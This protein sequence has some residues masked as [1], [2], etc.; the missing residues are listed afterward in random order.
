M[1]LDAG[2][3]R[4]GAGWGPVVLTVQKKRR[5]T[6][7]STKRANTSERLVRENW[8]DLTV[9]SVSCGKNLPF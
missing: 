2:Q 9:L 8:F 6:F 3:D 4:T 7:V 5:L 1:K